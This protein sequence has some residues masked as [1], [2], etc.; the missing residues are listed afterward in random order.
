VPVWDYA[1]P[2][3]ASH[4]YIRNHTDLGALE[5]TARYPALRTQGELEPEPLSEP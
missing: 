3:D 1:P 2:Y 4:R 5:A